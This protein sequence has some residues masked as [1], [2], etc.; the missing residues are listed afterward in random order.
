M[1][2]WIDRDGCI[3]CGLCADICP[4]V[5]RISEEDDL[6]EVYVDEIPEDAED[7]VQEAAESCPVSV[8]HFEED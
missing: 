2:V 3:S 4:E 6:A 7:L 5:F 1:K 8:I